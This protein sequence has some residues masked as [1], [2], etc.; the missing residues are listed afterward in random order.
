MVCVKKLGTN[1]MKLKAV[2][3]GHEP[4]EGGDETEFEQENQLGLETL[5]RRLSK[6]TEPR[7]TRK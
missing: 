7:Q 3:I 6:F 5:P 1:W 4:M 2:V